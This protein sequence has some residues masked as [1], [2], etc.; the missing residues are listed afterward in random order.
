MG[1]RRVIVIVLD[2]VGAGEAPDAA[3]YGDIGSNSLANTARAIAGLRLPNLGSLG[4]GNITSIVGVPASR[5]TSGAYGKMTPRSAGKDTVSGHW[6]LMGV[7]LSQAFPTYPRGFPAELIDEIEQRSKVGILGNKAASGTQIIQELGLEHIRTG[8][9]IVYTSADS[10]FQIAAHEEVIPVERLYQICEIAREVLSGEHAVGRVIARPF[11][12][13][14]PG[15]FRRTERR[16]D[17]PLKPPSPTILDVLARAGKRVHS[18]GKIDDI[19][20]GSG[21]TTARH[22]VSN[23]DSIEAILDSVAEDFDGLLFA[24]LIE[25]DMIFGHRNDYRGYAAALEAFDN[26]IAQI[27]PAMRRE[28]ICMIVA[29]HGVDPTTPSTDHSREYV[30]LLVFGH[31]IRHGADLGIRGTLADV[32]ATIAE[33]FQVEC[34]A[35]G[36]SFLQDVVAT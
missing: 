13:D 6:E 36:V 23:L 15:E 32:A 5:N 18:V 21:I 27:S 4:L 30:P 12:G 3:D 22:T 16:K 2:G 29:D 20:S 26:S 33:I 28:D 8:K 11:L 34:A 24:N 1:I 10:V 14:R 25:F 9:P 17:Y 7:Q 31:F 35:A 19:F